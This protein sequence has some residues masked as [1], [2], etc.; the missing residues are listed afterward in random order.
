MLIEAVLAGREITKAVVL[1]DEIKNYKLAKI[2]MI[3]QEARQNPSLL[4]L[5]DDQEDY[6][7]IV[8]TNKSSKEK[9]EKKQTHEQTLELLQ[10]GNSPQDVARIRQL[11]IRTINGHLAIL[12]KAEKLELKDVLSEKRIRDLENMFGD[13]EGTSLGP[14]KEK[15]GNKVT[16]DE[17]KLYQASTMR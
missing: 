4:D 17:L 1:N 7:S 9:K 14:L 2:A 8:K 15:L 13:Y 16:W 11:S 6:I 3:K 5:D 10:E 12:I